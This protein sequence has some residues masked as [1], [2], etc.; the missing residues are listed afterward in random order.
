MKSANLDLI[1]KI[2][3][4]LVLDTIRID[5]P[6]SRASISQKIGLSRSTV[7]LIVDELIAKKFV[8]ETG[9]GS[10]TREGGR[11]AIQLSFNPSSAYGVGI[12]LNEKGYLICVSD[13]DGKIVSLVKYKEKP[14][15]EKIRDHLLETVEQADV[16]LDKVISVG[17][18]VPGLTNS[19]DGIVV[20]APELDWND[21]HLAAQF[22]KLLDK[23]VFINND[24]NCA[25]L[26]ERWLGA[27][28]NVD[29]FI[30]ISIKAGIGSAMVCNG[31]LVQGKDFMAG[32]LGYFAFEED[33]LSQKVNT[34]GH[35]GTFDKKV[36][37]DALSQYASSIGEVFEQ[38]KRN[39]IQ[40]VRVVQR[41]INHLSLGI[42]NMVSLLNPEKVIIGGELGTYMEELLPE[43]RQTVE[44]ITPI[45]TR[46]E[47]T[48]VGE[49]SGVLGIISYSFDNVQDVIN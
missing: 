45:Q 33:L 17:F 44:R 28:Q 1:K 6:I 15:L 19:V 23:P 29:E 7:S 22:R 13:L 36:S 32:E 37:V 21:V 18:C 25:A 47:P 49:N 3:R 48:Q 8:S 5:Q 14:V 4:D 9:L 10:S 16:P 39:E 30:Y 12:E 42:A 2:N 40:A 41:F 43:V 11:R 46:I 24:V 38:Y 35:F 27:C 34:L 31:K 20:G 26:G